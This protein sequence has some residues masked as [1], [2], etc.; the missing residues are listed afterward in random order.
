M[1]GKGDQR[2]AVVV[3]RG[4]SRKLADEKEAERTSPSV[5]DAELENSTGRQGGAVADPPV[6]SGRAADTHHHN[7][8]LDGGVGQGLF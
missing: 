5:Q 3:T 4:Q 1:A 7:P 8:L 6:D 2:C